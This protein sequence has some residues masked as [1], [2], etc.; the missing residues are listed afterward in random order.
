MLLHN[1]TCKKDLDPFLTTPCVLDEVLAGTSM[2]TAWTWLS[3]G[4][5]PGNDG[6]SLVNGIGIM[7]R[8]VCLM[9]RYSCLVGLS[10]DSWEWILI[11]IL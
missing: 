11:L 2:A 10:W 6:Q 3:R 7:S 4:R 5:R 1:A 8:E 9:E